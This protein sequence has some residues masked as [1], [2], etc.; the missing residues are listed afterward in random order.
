[1]LTNWGYSRVYTV[2]VVNCTFSFNPN[3]DKGV[4]K[5]MVNTYHGIST[6]IGSKNGW[7][8]MFS[9]SDPA[10][11]RVARC[12]RGVPAGHGGSSGSEP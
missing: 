11:I 9:Y 3:Q 10:R 12:Q 4:E 6:P 2:V 8:T 5:L 7:L 1:M